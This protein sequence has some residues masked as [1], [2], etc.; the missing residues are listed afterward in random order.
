MPLR[1]AENPHTVPSVRIGL[2]AVDEYDFDSLT[3]GPDLRNILRLVFKLIC[4][5][6]ADQDCRTPR[7]D[8][9]ITSAATYRDCTKPAHGPQEIDPGEVADVLHDRSVVTLRLS[10]QNGGSRVA[11]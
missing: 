1:I 5:A 9:T 11:W 10:V 8:H 6:I 3:C 2:I 7:I 4:R